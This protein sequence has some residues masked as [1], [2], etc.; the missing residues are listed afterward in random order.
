MP[1]T[2]EE[3]KKLR[4]SFSLTQREA[5]ESVRVERQTWISWERDSDKATHRKIPE[6]LLELFFIKHHVSYKSLDNKVYIVYY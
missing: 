6:G 5:A 1:I 3:L 2:P 4:K